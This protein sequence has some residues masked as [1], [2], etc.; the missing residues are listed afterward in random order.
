[1]AFL[2][3]IWGFGIGLLSHLFYLLQRTFLLFLSSFFVFFF[4]ADLFIE[5]DLFLTHG[6]NPLPSNSHATSILEVPLFVRRLKHPVK[7]AGHLDQCH[8]QDLVT[9]SA[10]FLGDA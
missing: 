1:L 10:A 5:D 6:E 4:H 3:L 2:E 7:V 9:A 8:W